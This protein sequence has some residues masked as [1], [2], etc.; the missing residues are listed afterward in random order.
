LANRLQNH[1]LIS[2]YLFAIGATAIWSGNYIIARDLSDSIPPISLAFWRWLVAV[3]IILPF[4]IKPLI[5]EWGII[6]KN[7]PYLSFTSLMGVTIFNTL[8]YLAG[9]TTTA[10]NLSLIASTFPIFIILISRLL[11]KELITFNKSMGILFVAIGVLLL[12]TKGDLSSLLNISFAIGDVWMLIAAIT[13]AIYSI[14]L[15]HNPARLS[16]WAFQ[17]STFM[18]GTLFLFPFF[19]YEHLTIPPVHFDSKAIMSILYVGIFASFT[20]FI[21]WNK[22]IITIG[23][24]KSGIIYYTLPLFSGFLAY[25]FLD[26][27]I[28]ISHFFST[29][30]IISGIFTANYESGKKR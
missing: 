5:A 29:V 6:K 9:H 22:A 25:F 19:L 23:A 2:G 7:L 15:K 18:L 26:E 28:N 12:I 30:L 20:A 11:F 21:L 10:L 27:N 3:I 13:F 24:S 1:H 4:A 17:S 8:V 16:I 14:L